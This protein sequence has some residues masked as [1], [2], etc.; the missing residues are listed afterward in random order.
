MS[1]AE[2]KTVAVRGDIEAAGLSHSG[3]A[4]VYDLGQ[5]RAVARRVL[6]VEVPRKRIFFATMANDHP[7]ILGC[8]CELGIGAFVNSPAHL[9]LVLR[10]GFAPSQIV[11]AASNLSRSEMRRCVESGVSLVLDSIGQID[12]LGKLAPSDFTVGVRLNVGSA[13]DRTSLRID[14]DYRFGL[15]AEDL[16]LAVETARRHSISL[17]GAHAYFGTGIMRSELLLAGMKRL[18]EVAAGL[19]DLRYV[20]V[21]GGFGV[22]DDTNGIEFDLEAWASGAREIFAGLERRLGRTIELY[23]EPGR[24]LTASSGYFF[25]QVIDCKPRKD[26]VFV[27]TNGSVAIFPRPLLHGGEARH[28]C[29][30]LGRSA[31]PVHP[32]PLYICGNSTYSQDFLAREVNLPLPRPDDTLVFLQAG[33]Y[34]RSMITQFLGKDRPAELMVDGAG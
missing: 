25:V 21:G 10:S 16:P 33:A 26:R 28:P 17:V 1:D 32:L 19:P 22:P 7:A 34:G 31:G 6:A 11:Y 15:L 8:L 23:V 27:G 24:Y 29:C 12:M 14:P 4:Y 2:F 9:D 13:L 18:T 5:L 20:D 30:L 3:P